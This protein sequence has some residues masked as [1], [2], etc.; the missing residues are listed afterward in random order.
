MMLRLVFFFVLILIGTVAPAAVFAAS[1]LLYALCYTAYELL[2][3]AVFMDAYFAIGHPYVIPY[4]TI[5]ILIL[6]ICVEWIKPRISV[7][8]Q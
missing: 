8:N 6:L 5:G 7:Y 3:L 2:P 1:A 4:Y